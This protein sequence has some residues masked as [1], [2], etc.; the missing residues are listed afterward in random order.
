MDLIKLI[1]SLISD[2]KCREVLEELRWPNRLACIRCGST[3]IPNT[4]RRN[5]YDGGSCGYQFSVTAGSMLHDSH[6]P[7]K[8]WFLAIYLMTES[9][10]GLSALQLTR[11]LNIAYRTA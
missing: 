4:P 7:L 11:M 10:K 6:L 3:H 9:K 8:K 5:Q 2:E 1:L